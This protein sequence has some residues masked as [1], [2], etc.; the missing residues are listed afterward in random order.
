[1]TRSHLLVSA[2]VA[3]LCAGILALFTDAELAIL[4][5][6]DCGPWSTQPVL[7]ERCR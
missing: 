1:M 3:L 2:S 6:F 4:R 5:W 7:D